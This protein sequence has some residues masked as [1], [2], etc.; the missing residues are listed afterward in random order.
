MDIGFL[1]I[2]DCIQTLIESGD[3]VS[4]SGIETAVLISLFSDKRVNESELPPGTT[5]KRGWWGDMFPDVINDKIGS[6]LWTLEREKITQQ[7]LAAVETYAV[8]ALD[9]MIEDGV[10]TRIEATA[11]T[12]EFNHVILSLSIYRPESEVNRFNLTWDAQEL[13]RA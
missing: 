7:T 9:W 6:K 5:E 1:I 12:D 3:F 2:D 4:D 10:A 11:S 8:E 13:K